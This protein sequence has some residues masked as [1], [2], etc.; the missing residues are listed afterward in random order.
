MRPLRPYGGTYH[1]KF[2]FATVD[3][4]TQE[5]QAAGLVVEKCYDFERPTPLKAGE[6]GLANWARQFFASELASFSPVEQ[7][8]ILARL[9]A[10]VRDELWDG[11][12]WVADYRRIRCVAHKD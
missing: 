9:A 6:Q 2:N 5:A 7:D 11:H 8:E 1:P 12:Q 10:R 3:Q 4:L